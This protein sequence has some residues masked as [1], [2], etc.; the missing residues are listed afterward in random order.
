MTNIYEI[1]NIIIYEIKNVITIIYELYNIITHFRMPS[2]VQDDIT[3]HL[4]MSRHVQDDPP[5]GV[6]SGVVAGDEHV[7]AH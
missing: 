4:R 7:P 1:K 3:T 6:G 5:D 2:H